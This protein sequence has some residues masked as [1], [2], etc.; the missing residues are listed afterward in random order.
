MFFDNSL[1]RADCEYTFDAKGCKTGAYSTRPKW[2]AM[3]NRLRCMAW[4]CNREPCL[5][6]GRS[7]I[8]ELT[9]YTLPNKVDWTA[10]ALIIGPCCCGCHFRS[11]I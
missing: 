10:R 11:A 8:T 9:V 5:H 3:L 2:A 4:L 1:Y 6:R 7:Y